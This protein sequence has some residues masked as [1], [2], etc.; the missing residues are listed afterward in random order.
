MG[1][2]GGGCGGGG[3]GVGGGGWGWGWEGVVVVGEGRWV[4]ESLGR[5]RGE[6]DGG[7][8]WINRRGE[9]EEERGGGEGGER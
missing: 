4:G 2:G 3:G 1:W 8:V 6:E 7:R 5:Y 9:R